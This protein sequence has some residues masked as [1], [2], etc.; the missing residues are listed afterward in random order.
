M[1]ALTRPLPVPAHSAASADLRRRMTRARDFSSGCL[2]K[3]RLDVE[4]QALRVV[5]PVGAAELLRL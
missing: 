1:P 3:L 4:Q 5:V 2:G